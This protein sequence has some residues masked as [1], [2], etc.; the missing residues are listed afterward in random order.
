MNLTG[1]QRE[2][3]SLLQNELRVKRGS[4]RELRIVDEADGY[5]FAEVEGVTVLIESSGGRGLWGGYKLP[6]VRT[7]RQT[8]VRPNTALD[9]AIDASDH[10]NRQNRWDIANLSRAKER[11]TGHLG[12]LIDSDWNC[13]NNDCPCKGENKE[14][15]KE[16]SLG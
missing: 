10:W 15:R 9:A 5:V 12:P 1:Q 13:N 4:V 11:K 6:A 7:Y 14:R 2:K 16:R 8:G 3:I